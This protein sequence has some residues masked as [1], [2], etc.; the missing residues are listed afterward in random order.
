MHPQSTAPQQQSVS[1]ADAQAQH[2]AKKSPWDLQLS[3]QNP[4]GTMF[5]GRLALVA[6]LTGL[7]CWV[8]GLAWEKRHLAMGAWARRLMNGSPHL[9]RSLRRAVW[10]VSLALV[11][12]RWM[13][14]LGVIALLDDGYLAP[15]LFRQWIDCGVRIEARL[16][17]QTWHVG[18]AELRMSSL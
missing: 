7:L 15:V 13:L 2:P 11:W 6:G 18:M 16:A 10:A 17:G 9:P 8:K 12:T 14:L 4:T 3:A 1:P 5:A